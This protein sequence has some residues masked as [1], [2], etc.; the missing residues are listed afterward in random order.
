MRK[1]L[2]IGF[3]V[4]SVLGSGTKLIYETIESLK[5]EIL[6]LK[7]VNKKLVKNQEAIKKKIT[8]RRK[9]LVS[10]KLDRAKRKIIKAPSSMVPIVGAV[11]IVGFTTYEIREYC[12][13]IQEYKDFEKSIF[14]NVDQTITEDERLLC[15]LNV[16]EEL[17]PELK[18]YSNTS[19]D[20]LKDNYNNLT[21]DVF[22]YI[23]ELKK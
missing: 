13:D 17:L 3:V 4:I 12:S 1:Y 16:E 9:T 19:V 10:Q 22:K 8:D 2:I 6:D 20:W 14:A 15:G 23:E 18:K 5:K 7:N 21:I 11:A